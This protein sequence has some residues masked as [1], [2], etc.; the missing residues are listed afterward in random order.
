MSDGAV[1]Q[2]FSPG[3]GVPG[4][5][6]P[7]VFPDATDELLESAIRDAPSDVR[8]ILILADGTRYEGVLFGVCE[9]FLITCHSGSEN[10]FSLRDTFCPE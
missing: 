5:S 4:V 2:G 10:K 3:E 8:G 6:N 9:A 1:R 7:P